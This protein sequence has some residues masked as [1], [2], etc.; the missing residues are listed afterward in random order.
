[1]LRKIGRKITNNFGLKMLAAL[2]AI[3]L[4][5]VVVNIDD[6]ITTRT[7]TTGIIFEN[8]NYITS[9]NKYFE[10]LDGNNTISFQISAKRTV[11]EKLMN[12]D[13]RATANMEKIEFDAEK[14]TYQV[15]VVVTQSK[16]RSDEVTL[17]SK[18]LYAKVALEDLGRLQKPIVPQTSGVVAEGCAL[19]NVEIIGSNIVKIQGPSSV[20]SQIAK[21]AAIINVDGMTSDLTDS[22]VPV[23]YDKDGNVIDTTKLKLSISTVSI[24]A[25]ILNTKD[26]ALEFTTSGKPAEGYIA[27][28]ISYKPETVRIKGE[29]AV[30]NPINKITIPEEVLDLTDAAE[31]IETT[32]DISSYLPEGT[33]LVLN[34][35]AKV[36]VKV[37]VEP[38]KT[39]ILEVPAANLAVGNLYAGHK[40]E[41]TEGTVSIEI[42]GPESVIDALK[43]E[44]ITGVADAKGLGNGTHLLNVTFEFGNPNCELVTPVKIEATISGGVVEG[45]TP[46]SESTEQNH[47]TGNENTGNDSVEDKSTESGSAESESAEG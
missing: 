32:V 11:H 14:Q 41:I 31:T 24:S 47:N 18:N 29:A 10:V 1:M 15:P 16:Y 7:Y 19:G 22:V 34:S 23:F 12:T 17:V 33:S 28:G 20:V 40:A 42:S 6:P 9:E 2:C 5:V 3:V 37:E 8:Q 13:F 44:D 35:D 25:Q 26:V 27:T 36:E 30:L 21:V 43:A 38:V 46:S 45:N 39:R 4:W